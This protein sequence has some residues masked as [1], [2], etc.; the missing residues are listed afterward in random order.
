MTARCK[1]RCTG[2]SRSPKP[3]GSGTAAKSAEAA[4]R[5]ARR[6]CIGCRLGRFGSGADARILGRPP[7]KLGRLSRQG[8]HGGTFSGGCG[9]TPNQ[10]TIDDTASA[11]PAAAQC[12]CIRHEVA[13]L[14]KRRDDLGA[15]MACVAGILMAR[16]ARA[17]FRAVVSGRRVR[18]AA[19]ARRRTR[20]RRCRVR[21]GCRSRRWRAASRIGRAG[22]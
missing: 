17:H 7:R 6:E 5:G 3:A 10:T 4:A 1:Y 18:A 22:P 11:A 2:R 13:Q 14:A 12:G 8:G 21:S 20:T 16:C 9:T 15:R 19:A